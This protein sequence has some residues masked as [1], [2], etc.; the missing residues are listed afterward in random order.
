MTV[1]NSEE[2][3][4]TLALSVSITSAVKLTMSANKISRTIVP[5]FKSSLRATTTYT[6]DMGTIKAGMTA[7]KNIL[8]QNASLNELIG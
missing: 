5:K 4:Q 8:S 1:R 3:D 7:S 6:Q 2:F